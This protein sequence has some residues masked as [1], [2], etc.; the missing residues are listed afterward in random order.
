MVPV[1]LAVSMLAFGLISVL[2][3]DPA[4]MMLG[5][6]GSTST[7]SYRALREQLGLD[8][9][10][11]IRYLRWAGRALGG[12][13]GASLRTNL[14]IGRE[15]ASHIFPTLELAVLALL[16]AVLIAIPAGI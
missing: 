4:L 6:Q 1:A 7:G 3:G 15:I 10:L 11:P 8:E 16:L 5:E 2:P 9:P 14:P 12:D 13:F